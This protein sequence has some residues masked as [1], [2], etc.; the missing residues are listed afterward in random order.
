MIFLE[1]KGSPNSYQM[2]VVAVFEKYW[3]QLVFAF[4]LHYWRKQLQIFEN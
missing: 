3:Q 4:D 2:N 1:I